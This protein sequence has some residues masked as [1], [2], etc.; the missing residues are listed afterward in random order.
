MLAHSRCELQLLVLAQGLQV[1]CTAALP[2]AAVA[3]VWQ[4]VAGGA[5]PLRSAAL[6]LP[7]QMAA[8]LWQDAG[9]TAAPTHQVQ[10][11]VNNNHGHTAL[12]TAS[13]AVAD[14]CK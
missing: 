7:C 11:A 2:R 13:L 4:G 14:F 6:G 3:T 9:S 1:V 12:S 10:P 8:P 5:G